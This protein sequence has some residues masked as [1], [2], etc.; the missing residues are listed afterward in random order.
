MSYNEEIYAVPLSDVEKSSNRDID[1]DLDS[2][3]DII[4]RQFEIYHTK[5]NRDPKD[6]T[7]RSLDQQNNTAQRSRKWS[8]DGQTIPAGEFSSDFG[9]TLYITDLPSPYD[10]CCAFLTDDIIQSIVSQTNLYAALQGKRFKPTNDQ[11]IR[12]FIGINFLMGINKLPSCRDA[13]S[14]IP[15]LR[16]EYICRVMN[17]NRFGWLLSHIYLN[18]NSPT[19]ARESANYDKLYKIRPFLDKIQENLRKNYSPGFDQTISS[20]KTIK[21]GY[22]LWLLA[23]K[24]GYCYRFDVYTGK[25]GNQVTTN[26]GEKVVNT[27]TSD[28]VEKEH[29]IYFDNYFTSANLLENLKSKQI[30]ACGVVN[31]MRKHLPSFSRNMKSR[32]EYESF[33]SDTGIMATQWIDNKPVLFLSNFHSPKQHSIVYRRNRM[34]IRKSITCPS[35][36]A[37]YN[38]NMNAVD[39]FDQLM[40]NYSLHRRRLGFEIGSKE[41]DEKMAWAVATFS[42]GELVTICTVLNLD[43]TGQNEKVAHRIY[44][45]LVDLN[46]LNLVTASIISDQ[47]KIRKTML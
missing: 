45:H 4:V 26:L 5:K 16:N 8:P 10:V 24:S 15:Y 23:D 21:R 25:V 47:K 22:K 32:G 37:D 19:P 27:I 39:K 9:L 31:K 7:T 13:W 29:K 1:S 17:V 33:V 3:S 14:S 18:D 2:G 12:A 36:I 35:L 41:F 43:F 34:G 40:S 11:E 28:L 44:R 6:E 42:L 20:E 30:N 46:R 38:N